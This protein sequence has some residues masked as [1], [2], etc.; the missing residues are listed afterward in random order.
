[1]KFKRIWIILG[2]AL[3]LSL[4]LASCSSTPGSQEFT[5]AQLA[6]YDGL[7]GNRAYI[8]VSG[9][10]YDVTNAEGWNKGSHQS[11]EAGLDLTSIITGAPHGISVLKGLKVV[12]TLVD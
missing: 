4:G 1:M 10:V 8:A 3:L 9:K 7:N 12:G 5:I 6:A 2:L 11:V